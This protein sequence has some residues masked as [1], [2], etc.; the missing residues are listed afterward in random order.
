VLIFGSP[1]AGTPLMVAAPL[2]AL[3]L[4]LKA[5]VWQDTAG[6]THVSYTSPAYLAR[7]YAV[8]DDLAKN[9]AG[10]EPLLAGALQR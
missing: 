8:P 2:L 10:I 3:E 9:I 4:P 1:L 5:L 6:Q 7:R